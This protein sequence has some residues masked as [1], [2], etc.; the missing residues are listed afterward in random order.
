[1]VN[2]SGDPIRIGLIANTLF[3]GCANHRVVDAILGIVAKIIEPYL[4]ADRSQRANLLW[5]D[6]KTCF[7]EG[8]I[9][10]WL[11]TF[12]DEAFVSANRL[13]DHAD[14]TLAFTFAAALGSRNAAA[15]PNHDVFHLEYEPKVELQVKRGPASGG[16]G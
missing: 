6:P 2:L 1:M 13:P 7:V 10:N 12:G 14:D 16:C 5:D 11:N 4:F 3:D 9:N 15:D 8:G